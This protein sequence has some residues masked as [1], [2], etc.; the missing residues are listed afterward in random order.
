MNNKKLSEELLKIDGI[1]PAKI[2][3]T[4]RAMFRQML[5]KEKKHL[6]RL[7]RHSLIEIGILALVMLGLCMSE[8]ILETLHIPFVVAWM[9]LLIVTYAAFRL[10]WPNHYRQ[11]KESS[12]IVQRLHFIV[13]GKY[14]G[15][16]FMGKKDGK[17]YIDWLSIL[18]FAV[19]IWFVMALGCVGVYYLLCRRWILSEPAHLF[20]IPLIASLSFVISLLYFGIKTPLE[21]L[22]EIKTENYSCS[23]RKFSTITIAVI[24]TAVIGVYFLGSLTESVAWADVVRPILNARTVVFNV[25]MAEGENVPV[26]RVMNMGTQRVRSE[27]LSPDGKTVQAIAIIDFDTS[28]VLTLNPK[29]KIAALIDLKDLP[30]KPENILE[31][32]RNIIT[33]LQN[34]PDVLI[35]PLGEKEIDGRTAKGFRATGPDEELTIWVDSQTA[36]PIRIEQKGRQIQFACTDFQFDIEMDESLF[37]MEIP[38]GYPAPPMVGEIPISALLGGTEQDLVE[39]LR[40]YAGIILDG[41]FPED[42]SPQVWTDDVKKNRNKFAQLS[43]EKKLKGPPLKFARGWVFF[44]LLKPENDWNYVGGGVKFGDAE[45]PVCWYRPNGSEAYRVI[46][47][48]LSIKDVAPEDLPK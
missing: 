30:E 38:E 43:E 23:R 28:R 45:S 4:E 24:I 2:S 13:R 22:T 40:I 14:K 47:G 31:E 11:I 19:A 27:V 7:S 48:D 33:D 20:Y 21:E 26:T 16:P 46:Y 42:L 44:R 41:A 3:D 9:V 39:F 35:E 10:L 29:Q 6:K 25:I 1:D 5:D 15:F 12:K 8:R 18:L 34:D 37:S 32:M 36:L 17:R